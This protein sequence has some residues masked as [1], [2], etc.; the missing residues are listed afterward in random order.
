[1]F[2]LEVLKELN[3]E[4]VKI[5]TDNARSHA[6]SHLASATESAPTAL[7]P[8]LS[9]YKQS[10]KSK[11]G[12]RRQRRQHNTSDSSTQRQFRKVPQAK[13]RS[14]FEVCCVTKSPKMPVRRISDSNQ[15]STASPLASLFSEA[16]DGIE[17]LDE[18]SDDG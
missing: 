10:K 2:H 17:L 16:M 9:P 12:R 18:D 4:K 14:R 13:P 11:S 5:V 3:L 6:R 1:M 8:F 7:L 15:R